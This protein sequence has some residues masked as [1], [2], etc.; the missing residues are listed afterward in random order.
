MFSDPVL[1]N[2][3]HVVAHLANLQPGELYTARL[4]EEDLLIWLDNDRV[5]V[6]WDH[7]PHRGARLSHGKVKNRRVICPYHGLEFAAGG[8]CV[9]V[10]SRPQDKPPPKARAR[11]C[12]VCVRYGLVWVSL[13]TPAHDVFEFPEIILG[14]HRL[15]Y[16]GCFPC[17]TSAPRLIENFLDLS[18]FPFVHPGILGE[19]PH[20]SVA[21]YCAQITPEGLVV[22][23]CRVWQ[24]NPM[25]TGPLGTEGIEVDYAYHVPR[26]LTARLT[27]TLGKCRDDGTPSLEA[28]VL[29]ASPVEPEKSIGWVLIASNY[30]DNFT[31]DQVLQSSKALMAQDLRVIETQRPKRLPLETDAEVHFRADRTSI[32][33]RKWLRQLDVKFGTTAGQ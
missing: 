29:T 33:Y 22:N 21:D 19:E 32:Q 12:K 26:P 20:T 2:D 15:Y 25:N 1:V 23:G 13:G 10:P 27:K 17:E 28:I 18:H 24:P 7:C 16:G 31:Q 11:T 6:W 3:W 5:E 9:R 4:M 8:Q 14:N 30:E